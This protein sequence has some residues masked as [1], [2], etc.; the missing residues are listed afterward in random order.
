MYHQYNLYYSRLWSHIQTCLGFSCDRECHLDEDLG[1]RRNVAIATWNSKH[2][3]KWHYI[4]ELIS[5]VG[6]Q[7]Y[8]AQ[9]SQ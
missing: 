4:S 1:G 9:T 8:T 2:N 7:P 3:C 6:S 5:T